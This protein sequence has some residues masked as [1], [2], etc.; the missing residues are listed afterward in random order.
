MIFNLQRI[1]EFKIE[2]SY[3]PGCE[4]T[5]ILKMCNVSSS[6]RERITG[7][8]KYCTLGCCAVR[9]TVTLY[10]SVHM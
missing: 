5:A 4:V 8:Q 1:S 9:R 6:E 3:G 7:V 2:K 10:S